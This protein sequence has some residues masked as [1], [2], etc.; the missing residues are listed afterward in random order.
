MSS[1]VLSTTFV[2]T[3]VCDTEDLYS[4][5]GAESLRHMLNEALAFVPKHKQQTTPIT[6]KATAGLR[7]LPEGAADNILNEVLYCYNLQNIYICPVFSLLH[8]N[9]FKSRVQL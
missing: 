1:I 5:Q 9:V 6:L 3:V 2:E 7:L 4:N 8:V